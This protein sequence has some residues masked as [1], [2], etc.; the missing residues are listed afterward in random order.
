M[1]FI[2]QQVIVRTA[3]GS[4]DEDME[5]YDGQCGSLKYAADWNSLN[6]D[7]HLL[8]ISREFSIKSNTG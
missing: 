3:K 7:L 2:K 4:G 1:R 6:T 8:R 5:T